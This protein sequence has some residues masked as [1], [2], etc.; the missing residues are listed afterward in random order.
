M[1]AYTL[2][3][4][5]CAASPP[6]SRPLEAIPAL[7]AQFLE[8]I[9]G[10]AA[11]I[12]RIADVLDPAPPDLVGTPYVAQKLGVTTTWVAD[13]VRRGEIPVSC[14]VPGTGNGKPWKFFRVQIDKWIG[15]R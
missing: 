7:H 9:S 1:N 5:G 14:L 15:S 4:P 13:M 2:H 8:I 12:R 6:A 10:V 3:V 11:D